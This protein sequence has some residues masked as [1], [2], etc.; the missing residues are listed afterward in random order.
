MKKTYKKI[1]M[2][3]FSISLLNT[4]IISSLAEP[5]NTVA[6][7]AVMDIT[8]TPETVLSNEIT[9]TDAVVQTTGKLSN[10]KE[11]SSNTEKVDKNTI[12]ITKTFTT[13]NKDDF[14]RDLFDDTVKENDN[15]YDYDSMDSEILK[16]EHVDSEKYVYET[17]KEDN[18]LD[19]SEPANEI[20]HNG[21][22]Y[23]LT[24]KELK[25]ETIVGAIRHEEKTY[26]IEG[27]EGNDDIPKTQDLE[28]TKTDGTK[29]KATLNYISTVL[30]SETWQNNFEFPI[31][32]SGYDADIFMLNNTE[33]KKGDALINYKDAF[34]DYLGLPESAYRITSIEWDGDE[35]TDNGEICRNAVAKGDKKV[36]T[37]V[38]KYDGDIEGQ[39]TVK[40]YYSCVYENSETK[41][42]T[43]YTV[44]STAYYK[45]PEIEIPETTESAITEPK[46]INKNVLTQIFD[47]VKETKI[48]GISIG[49]LGLVGIIVL[50]LFML[51]KNKKEK[52]NNINI[53]D[54]DK[55]NSVKK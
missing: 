34:L 51:M 16:E 12:K 41:N 28:I 40:Y 38:A 31:K 35:Y 50:V 10:L 17:A 42:S 36:K 44:K 52:E 39:D 19:V 13:N 2:F 26:T 55:N 22:K 11:I 5:E 4:N 1:V 43:E 33:I 7:E 37:V 9:E 8:K 25:E 54:I 14:G 23:I 15:I 47:W 18:K 32:F 29:G 24:S 49:V 30:E 21:K 45:L 46:P 6:E 3:L 53:V 48:A 27:I 20:E